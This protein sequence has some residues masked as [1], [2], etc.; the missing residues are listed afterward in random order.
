MFLTL[1]ATAAFIFA[2]GPIVRGVFQHGA[3]NAADTIRCAWALSAFSIG[4]PSYVLVKVLTPGFYARAD[5]R[6][7][8]RYAIIS[9]GVNIVLNL[10]LIP[11]LGDQRPAARH[12]DRLQ[13]QCRHAVLDAPQARPFRAGCAAAPSDSAPAARL[14]DDGRSAV[15]PRAD[16]RTLI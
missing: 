8:V 5:T 15:F 12:R 3:F 1:P 14:V 2:S 4:L 16:S 13:R 7:P 10:V 6:T 9:V 11:T